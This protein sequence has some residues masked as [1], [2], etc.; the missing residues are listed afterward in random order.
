M[1]NSVLPRVLIPLYLLVVGCTGPP[2]ISGQSGGSLNVAQAA[3]LAQT[4]QLEIAERAKAPQTGF[5]PRLTIT[6][7]PTI[8][9][10]VAALDKN[11]PWGPLARCLGQFRLSFR[12]ASGQVQEFEYF[13]EGAANPGASFLRGSQPFWQGQQVQP[14]A[15]FE[16]SIQRL[17]SK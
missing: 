4:T 7:K 5:T 2:G 11:L 15:E 14:P 12:L 3:N 6:D 1:R 9:Q 8:S 17:L 10:L 13:C 16:Q